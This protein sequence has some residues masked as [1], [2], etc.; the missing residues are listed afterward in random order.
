V[1]RTQNGAVTLDS[2]NTT[3]RREQA[4]VHRFASVAVTRVRL[5]RLA[6]LAHVG[7]FGQFKHR[8]V[9]VLPAWILASTGQ[10]R[11]PSARCNN[12]FPVCSG[13]GSATWILEFLRSLRTSTEPL[14]RYARRKNNTMA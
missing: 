7:S 9:G 2:E 3:A 10:R 13:V 6:F 5:V 12:R 14:P 4:N 11:K 1:R 8:S